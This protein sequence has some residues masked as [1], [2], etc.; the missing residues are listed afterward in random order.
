VVPAARSFVVQCSNPQADAHHDQ[1][2]APA[3][4]ACGRAS[5]AVGPPKTTVRTRRWSHGSLPV[6]HRVVR[7]VQV[8]RSRRTHRSSS[9]S[10]KLQTTHTASLAGTGAERLPSVVYMT[11]R[12]RRYCHFPAKRDDLARSFDDRR[13]RLGEAWASRRED[14]R[15]QFPP[16]GA[17][18][19]DPSERGGQAIRMQR[20]CSTLRRVPFSTISVQSDLGIRFAA[21]Q[22]GATVSMLGAD[23]S[24]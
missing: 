2:N 8:G 7:G 12:L 23:V 18:R 20:L 9:T 15:L 3:F 19:M 5:D 4:G 24:G 17:M 14:T 21:H 10:S 6:E 1:E 16:F 22:V 11:G 13:K